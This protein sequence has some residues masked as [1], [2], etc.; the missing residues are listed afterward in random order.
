ME[1]DF[2]SGL[3]YTASII[4]NSEQYVTFDRMVSRE[5]S[6]EPKTALMTIIKGTFSDGSGTESDPILFY[7]QGLN[8]LIKINGIAHDEY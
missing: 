1:Y 8:L 6:S 4:N 7:N 3:K 2:C 5:I